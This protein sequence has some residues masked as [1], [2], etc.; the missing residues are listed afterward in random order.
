M[1]VN[2]ITPEVVP[3]TLAKISRLTIDCRAERQSAQSRTTTGQQLKAP[4]E[5]HANSFPAVDL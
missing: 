1:E 5:D 2:G 3:A 4:A